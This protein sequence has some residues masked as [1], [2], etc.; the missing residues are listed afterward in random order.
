[1]KNLRSS[2]SVSLLFFVILTGSTGI[3]SGQK[4]EK[5]INKNYKINEGFSLDITNKYGEINLVNWEKDEL[6]VEVI[7]TT[8][9]SS[10]SKAEELL[11]DVEIELSENRSDVSFTT[12]INSKGMKGN[13]KI[14]VVY[15]VKTPEYLNVALAQSYGNI[16]IQ[17][18]TGLA[19][20]EL[21][22][23]NL[24]A[25]RLAI[26]NQDVWNNLD[27]AYGKAAIEYANALKIQIK[28]SE[29]N[30]S[31]SDV[32][33]IESAYSKLYL[34]NLIDLDIESKY[35]K[36]SA[37][38]LEGSFSVESEYTQ[39]SVDRITPAFTGIFAEMKYG[40][41]KGGIDKKTAFKIDAEAS[42]GSIIIPEGDY[43]SIKDGM[44]EE[45]HGNVGGE[46][47]SQVD[48][49]IKYGNFVLNM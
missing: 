9:A 30:I 19:E 13:N 33:S 47:Q 37:N 16:Y 10:Q 18:I 49:S 22:Y 1:M 2:L 48:V 31:G 29:L 6:S 28:Y 34:G 36:L 45:A 24:T 7:I 32:L 20:I 41:F 5:E 25:N 43:Q 8:E 21:K 44:Q 40:N 26:S 35:D 14:K 23:G 46:T 11:K 12:R 38:L 39:I 15:N 42:Y 27:L 3:A 17:D 4:A